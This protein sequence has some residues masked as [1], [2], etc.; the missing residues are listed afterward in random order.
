MLWLLDLTKVKD[1]KDPYPGEPPFMKL[2]KFPAV[3]RYHKF[4]ISKDPDSYW[5][6]EA[7]L[8]MP[9]ENEEDLLAK[10]KRAKSGG[11]ETWQEFVNQKH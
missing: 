10:I 1:L 5:F 8:Y 11:L 3:L 2:R 7:M 6:S 9:H 4:N